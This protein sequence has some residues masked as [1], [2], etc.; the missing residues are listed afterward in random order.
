MTWHEHKDNKP[1]VLVVESVDKDN[2]EIDWYLEHNGDC[3]QEEVDF[4][5]TDFTQ[6]HEPLMA[7]ICLVQVIF[8]NEGLEAMGDGWYG[9]DLSKITVGRHLIVGCSSYDDY[10]KESELWLERIE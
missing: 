8:D 5:S 6:K 2:G 1:H 3:K 7:Y 4:S 9:F 10:N